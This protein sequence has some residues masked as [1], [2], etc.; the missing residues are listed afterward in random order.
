MIGVS[1]AVILLAGLLRLDKTAAILVM[2]A[3]FA[4]F[5]FLRGTAIDRRELGLQVA[6]FVGFGTLALWQCQLG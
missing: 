6:G 2:G 4:V 3:G 1:A 5:G